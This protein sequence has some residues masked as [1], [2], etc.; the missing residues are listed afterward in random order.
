MS[1]ISCLNIIQFCS[2]KINVYSVLILQQGALRRSM[3][4]QVR[5]DCGTGKPH[6]SGRTL[7]F[8]I[9]FH[10]AQE[11]SFDIPEC[12]TSMCIWKP[13]WIS[14]ALEIWDIFCSRLAILCSTSH[15]ILFQ[16]PPPRQPPSFDLSA[17]LLFVPVL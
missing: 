10:A 7:L 13:T 14:C 11:M 6:I 1:K 2:S 4:H 8:R 12:V 5:S 3:L 9:W 17:L 16:R 15:F